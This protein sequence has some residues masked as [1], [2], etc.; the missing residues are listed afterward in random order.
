MKSFFLDKLCSV[1]LC[2]CVFFAVAI[3]VHAQ[4]KDWRPVTP[5]ELA[6]KT[7]VVETDADAEHRAVP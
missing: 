5:A 3:A 7:P 2:S 4:D 1:L 6:A